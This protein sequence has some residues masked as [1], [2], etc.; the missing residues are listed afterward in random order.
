MYGG[1]VYAGAPYAGSGAVAVEP[2]FRAVAF[3]MR[4][5]GGVYVDFEAAASL[6]DAGV[7]AFVVALPYPT[8]TLVD[9]RPT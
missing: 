3:R 4:F 6:R 5:G 7:H 8:P 9:G 1:S 2:D